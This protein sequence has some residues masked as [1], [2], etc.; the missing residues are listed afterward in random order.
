VVRRLEQELAPG[1]EVALVSGPEPGLELEL[2]AAAV[3]VP[4]LAGVA[5]DQPFN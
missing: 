2:L 1:L 3:L 5:K 4:E